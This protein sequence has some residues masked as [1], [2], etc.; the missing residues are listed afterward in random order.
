MRQ[1]RAVA[2]HTSASQLTVALQVLISKRAAAQVQK[3]ASWWAE[4]RAAAPGAVAED[5]GTAIKLLS[6]QP[7]I[8]SKHEGARTLDVRRLYLRRIGYFIYYSAD[9]QTLR[10]LAFWSAQRAAQ[11]TL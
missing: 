1:P 4:N 3:C 5:V 7:G 9:S 6:Q 10:I 2:A 11:P 8:G